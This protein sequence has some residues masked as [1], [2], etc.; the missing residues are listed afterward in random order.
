MVYEQ[1]YI[2]N[3]IIYIFNLRGNQRTQ[4]DQSRK[5]GGKI[6]GSGSRA[7][8]AI[9]VL[10]K[11]GS[12]QHELLYHDIGDYLS[13]KQKLKIISDYQSIKEV[14]WEEIN[15]DVNNDWLNQRDP[16]YQKY[17]SIANDNESPFLINAMG[18]KTNRDTWIAGFSKNKVL[19]NSKRLIDNYNTEVSKNGGLGKKSEMRDAKK[20]KWSANLDKQFKLGKKIPFNVECL[21]LE[22]YRPFTKKWLM[23]DRNI[24][25]R[26][27]QYYELWGKSNRVIYTTGKGAN[28]PFSTLVTDNMPDIQMMMNGQGFMR[29]NHSNRNEL[30]HNANNVNEKFADKLGLNIDDTFAYV[31]ALLNSNEYQQRYAN[32]LRKDLARIP[33]VKGV[34]KYVNIGQKLINLHLNYEEVPTYSKVDIQYQGTPN[35]RVTKMKFTKK[36]NADGKLENDRS[37]I[38]LNDTI[39]ISNIPAKAYQYIVN[40]RSAI[41]W[42]MDQYRV[43]TD[44]KSGITDDPNDYSD[45]PKY[46]FNLLLRIINVSVQTVDLI[47]QLPKLQIVD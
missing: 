45:D 41:E 2:E 40:G 29:F 36:R 37:T 3:L 25:E 7:P 42:I 27:G 33:I 31:Y 18:I 8:I 4:G 5:E 12:D 17:P 23:Y 10:I 6:F 46:I 28:R 32:D 35:Y 20:I 11:D 47:N 1:L 44:K 19:L 14:Q 13:R 38:V 9:S 34:E 26:P 43:K 16:H 21:R 22:M 39:S 15:P 30:I 24:V